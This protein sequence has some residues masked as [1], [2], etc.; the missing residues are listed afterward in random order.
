MVVLVTP[1]IES[2]EFAAGCDA[3]WHC[4]IPALEP[5]TMNGSRH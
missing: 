3:L 1:V 4:T 5:G 2:A